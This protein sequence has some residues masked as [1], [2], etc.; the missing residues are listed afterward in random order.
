M[1]K[2]ILLFSVIGCISSGRAQLAFD[3]TGI[4]SNWP[5]LYNS[6]ESWMQGAFDAH[7]DPNNPADFGWGNYDV[8]T[9]FIEGDSIYILKTVNGNYKAISIDQLASGIYT[10]TYS[11]LDGNN[12][13]TKTIDRTPYNTKNF[14]YYSLDNETTKDLEPAS[15]SWDIV[16]TKYLIFFPGFGGYGVSGVLHNQGV[17]VSQ[18]EKAPGVPATLADTAQFPFSNDISTVGYDWKDAFAGVVYD[19][20]TYYVKDQNGQ[21]NELVLAGYGGSA[22]GKMLFTVNGQLD[23]ISLSPGNVDQVY[24]SLQNQSQVQLNQDNDWDVAFFA[25]S[26]FDAIPV[27]VN[28]VNGTELYVYPNADVNYFSLGESNLNVLSVYPN[29]AREVLNIVLDTENTSDITLS[30]TNA[31]G[32]VVKNKQLSLYTTGL[33]EAALALDGLTPGIYFLQVSDA[34]GLTA[35]SRVVVQP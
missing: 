24:Y 3:T 28:D 19:T 6:Y 34:A 11:D 20:L 10:F 17:M 26:S 35:T 15:A 2:I 14:F 31:S 22:T 7:R 13:V 12:R 33:G 4:G 1:K 18:V 32:Q 16:F 29:P 23:S 8:T 9:H 30:L 21:I 5:R 27:R 25:Q